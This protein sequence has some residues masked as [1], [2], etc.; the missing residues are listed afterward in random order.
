[1][2]SSVLD[3]KQDL[4]FY[5]PFIR[6]CETRHYEAKSTIIVEGAESDRLYLILEGTVAVQV[7]EESDPSQ[8]MVVAYLGEG[9]FVGELGFLS[10]EAIHRSAKIVTK[11]DCHIASITYEKLNQIRSKYPDIILAIA[12]QVASR[13]VQTTRKLRDLTFVDVAGRVA[14]ALLDLAQ[15]PEA[16]EHPEGRLIRITRQELGNL[17]GCSREMAGRV[18]KSLADDGLVVITGQTLLVRLQD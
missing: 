4:S 17:V 3:R 8:L 14:H 9:E 5:K 11:T 15:Q 13:L 10:A 18:L 1:M 7:E 16:Q 2:A 12:S 6:E